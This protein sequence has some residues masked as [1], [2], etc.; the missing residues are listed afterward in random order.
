M[1]ENEERG[2]ALAERAASLDARKRAAEKRLDDA[3]KA[4]TES[5]CVLHRLADER[6]ALILELRTVREHETEH[7]S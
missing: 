7:E 3:I 4:L 1:R 6:R 2:A 5:Q